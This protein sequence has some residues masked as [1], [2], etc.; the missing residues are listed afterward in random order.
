MKKHRLTF[1]Y[2]IFLRSTI[3]GLSFLLSFLVYSS[4][5]ADVSIADA[6]GDAAGASPFS[7]VLAMHIAANDSNLTLELDFVDL[8][9]GALGAILLDL[10]GN[11]Q[12]HGNAAGNITEARIEFHIAILGICTAQFY[13]GAGNAENLNCWVLGNSFYTVLPEVLLSSA[14][15]SL[16]VAAVAS[17]DFLCDGRDRVPD[18]GYLRMSNG[19]VHID[20]EGLILAP[21]SLLT[22][23]AEA[24]SPVDLQGLHI[25]VV[26]EHLLIRSS[27]HHLMEPHDINAASVGMLSMDVDGDI[28]T[29]FQNASGVFPTLGVDAYVDYTVYPWAEGGNVDVS[30]TIQDPAQSE[31]TSSLQVGKFSS[32]SCFL[33]EN[34]FVELSI[35]LSFLPEITNDAL[36]LL[37]ALQP[38]TGLSDSF[39]DEGALTLA[40]GTVT[41]FNNCQSEESFIS[42]PL[43]DSFAFGGDNDD[44]IEL[45]ACSYAEGTLLSVQYSELQLIGEALTAIRFDI[46]QNASTGERTTN[47]TG[48]TERGV[49]KTFVS[50]SDSTSVTAIMVEGSSGNLI[51]GISSLYTIRFGLNRMY[52]TIPNRLLNDYDGM[53]IHAVTMSGAFG[54][55]TF[56]DEIPN[57]GV[58]S[59]PVNNDTDGDG[60][61]DSWERDNFGD[62]ATADDTTDYDHDGLLDEDEYLHSSDPKKSDTDGDGFTDGEEVAAGSDPLKN[63]IRP[64]QLTLQLRAGFNLVSIPVDVAPFADAYSLL[65]LLGDADQIERILRFDNTTG[66]FQVVTYDG[67]GNPTGDN[68]PL[69]SGE[70]IVVYSKHN[71]TI[72]FA[73]VITCPSNDLIAGINLKGFPC[74]PAEQ[75]AF[76]VLQDIG[77]KTVVSS[78]QHFDPV[79]GKF[80]TAVLGSSE[81]AEG[82]DFPIKPEEGYFLF[83]RQDLSVQ[84]F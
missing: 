48:D 75:T 13:D 34:N 3:T 82:D 51:R 5:L 36:L 16:E 65:P 71:R 42:D 81:Q 39:P 32:D 76:S 47:A 54:T 59:L 10:D 15:E 8:H 31:E 19:E 50:Q 4:A 40:D 69:I 24:S 74:S 84:V 57:S 53:D 73:G 9:Q 18:E 66:R 83:M 52:V 37:Q 35:P 17:N 80:E 77:D 12:T 60:I 20:N 6:A 55:A 1:S 56:D 28:L 25:E 11:R 7:D 44:L 78:I 46:D 70:G 68:F 45:R 79:T 49:E 43:G 41:P 33:R 30:L 26:G 63:T 67:E 27:Y 38:E 72:P 2:G 64:V 21:L 23:P 58:F 61:P 62:L 22:D 29:G 14:I